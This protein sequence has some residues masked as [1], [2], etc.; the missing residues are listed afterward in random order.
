MRL[1]KYLKVARIL[2]RR[3]VSKEL[4]ESQRVYVNGRI[5]KPSTTVKVGDE[6]RVIFGHRELLVRVMMLAKQVNKN[7][8]ALMFEVLEEKQVEQEIK[9][10]E[11][12]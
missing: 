1:D 10:E 2:K 11:A 5:A 8:A 3:S 9:I 6:I 12:E 7:D 4:A